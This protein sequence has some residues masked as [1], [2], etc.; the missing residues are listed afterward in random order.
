MLLL[1]CTSDT[2]TTFDQTHRADLAV[3]GAPEP[4][5]ISGALSFDRFQDLDLLD[6][7]YYGGLV[8]YPG[9]LSDVYMVRFDLAVTDESGL[10]LTWLDE[11][12]VYVEAPGLPTVRVAWQDEFPPGDE[13]VSFHMDDIDLT[14][15]VASRDITFRPSAVG[16]LPPQDV[17]IEAYT[18]VR[19][20]VTTQGACNF[21]T[22]GY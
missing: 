5:P 11:V 15:Y 4:T 1:A 12:W 17:E 16:E 7:R 13:R 10:D 3:P 8:V 2:L 21:V 20:G 9:D 18:I 6:P 19:T 22:P 14:D